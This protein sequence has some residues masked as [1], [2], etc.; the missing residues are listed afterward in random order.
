MNRY[1]LQGL[2]RDLVAGQRVLVVVESNRFAR[3]VLD[4]LAAAAHAMSSPPV[5]LKVRRANG[6]EGLSTAA[7]GRITFHTRRSPNGL[8]GLA[9]DVVFVNVDF[10]DQDLLDSVHLILASRRGELILR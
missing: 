10:P 9:A 6:E 8:R 4:E 1:V 5:G 2:L 7:G 3:L